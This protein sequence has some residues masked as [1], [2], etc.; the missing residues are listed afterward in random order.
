MAVSQKN[1]NTK[2]KKE[3]K[4]EEVVVEEPKTEPQPKKRGLL[5][6]IFKILM[7]VILFFALIGG[8]FAVGVYLNF[9]TPQELGQKLELNKYPIIGKY[10]GGEELS[11]EVVEEN[12]QAVKVNF[13]PAVSPEKIE[14]NVKQDLSKP[15]AID[16]EELKRQMELAQKEEL[17][18]VGKLAVLYGSMKP[19]EAVGLME[20]LED[21]IVLAIFSKME[22]EQVAKILARFEPDRGA[23]L[24]KKMYF[25]NNIKKN[26]QDNKNNLAQT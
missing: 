25:G 14:Q 6:R 13:P 4:K 11:K 18:R 15:V 22:D 2:V 24:T 20:K 21:K 19:D 10:F 23:E 8:G 26:T 5:F 17:K 1:K 16:K 3:E 9:F 12:P 7:I